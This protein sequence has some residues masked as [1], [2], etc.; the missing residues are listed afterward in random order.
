MD[1]HDELALP[2]GTT[3]WEGQDTYP[4]T[5]MRTAAIDPGAFV[6]GPL[7]EIWDPN[8]RGIFVAY[9]ASASASVVFS[10]PPE[11]SI[12]A[13]AR[14]PDG[15]TLILATR[16][17]E[18]PRIHVLDVSNPPL[19]VYRYRLAE[20]WV[21]A[22]TITFT[23]DG[24]SF[25]TDAPEIRFWDLESGALTRTLEDRDTLGCVLS[26]KGRWVAAWT[27]PGALHTWE[28]DGSRVYYQGDASVTVWDLE[29]GDEGRQAAHVFR[30]DVQ[31]LVFDPRDEDV[32]FVASTGWPALRRIDLDAREVDFELDGFSALSLAVS[33]D[34]RMLATA[35][36]D[37]TIRLFDARK[38]VEL[39]Q[40]PGMEG[41]VHVLAFES[42]N[43]ILRALDLRIRTFELSPS[44][45]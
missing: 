26:P 23:P 9:E 38:G 33:S 16:E 32:L 39:D 37:R 35:G 27:N 44:A 13:S 36:T 10:V 14:S 2:T 21:P 28:E 41:E 19:P 42:E 25:I 31:A 6:W 20:D 3:L 8:T 30:G 17:R 22:Y 34:G 18:D 12:T 24:R 15:Q 5:A 45:P 29:A 40:I 4:L 7:A 43:T 1:P 11:A